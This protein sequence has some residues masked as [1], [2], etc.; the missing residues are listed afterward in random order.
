M[1]DLIVILFQNKECRSLGDSTT[2][3]QDETVLY[4]HLQ[5]MY[6]HIDTYTIF[7]V[8]IQHSTVLLLYGTTL[9]GDT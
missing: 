9:Y 2:V 1:N 6:Y 3:M 5:C 4:L 7:V 8:K